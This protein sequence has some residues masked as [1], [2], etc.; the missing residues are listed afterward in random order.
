VLK[1]PLGRL[2]TIAIIEGISFLVLLGVAMPLKHF[3]GMPEAVKIVG[4]M[5]GILFI[6]YVL[7]VMETAKSRKWPLKRVAF[8]LVASV[9]P[10]GPFV[11]EPSLKR[12][13]LAAEAQPETAAV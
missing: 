4:W 5:H 11:M 13:Q 10:A 9:L 6:L 2:R 7:A 12:E 1:T 3:A 8:A